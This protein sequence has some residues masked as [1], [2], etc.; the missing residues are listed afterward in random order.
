M[1]SIVIPAHNEG[2][3][4]PILIESLLNLAK[5][6]KWSSYE[7]IIVNDNSTDDTKKIAENFARKYKEIMV[8]NREKGDNGMGITLVEGTRAAKGDVVIWTMA[9]RS[10]DINTYPRIIEKLKD[11]DMVFGSRYIKE[12]SKGD[13]E[14]N[15]AFLSSSYTR[16]ARL[17]FGIKVH[18]ITNAFRGFK[19][20]VFA[21]IDLKS[22]DFAIS[23][24]F[25]IR[26]HLKDFKLGE[27]PTTYSNR[28]A[29]KPN[30][31]MFKMGIKYLKLFKYRFT[32]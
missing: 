3:N 7:V 18:D 24:E 22:K 12:G 13:L 19:K 15:K 11:Y 4:L 5:K 10:D 32:K 30:F 20:K 29:G 25:A 8:V 9:D 16:L 6:E 26:A 17:V 31:K 28:K 2:G 14:W 21:E 27:V 23:P 1:L